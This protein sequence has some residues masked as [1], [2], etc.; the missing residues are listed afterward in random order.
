MESSAGVSMSTCSYFEVKW[1]VNFVLFSTKNL[2]K[3][4]GHN[5]NKL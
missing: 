4:F 2:G 3:S 5:I 1:A